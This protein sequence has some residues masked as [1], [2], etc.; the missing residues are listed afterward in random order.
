MKEEAAQILVSNTST[1][2]SEV[3]PYLDL[4]AKYGYTT[5]VVTMNKFHDNPSVH[6]VPEKTIQAQIQRFEHKLN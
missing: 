2:L 4:A 1:R 5:F 3:Q 6:N